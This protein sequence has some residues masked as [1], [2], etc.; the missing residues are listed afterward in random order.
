MASFDFTHLP[1]GGGNLGPVV[2]GL[3]AAVNTAL[4]VG[5]LDI[6]ACFTAVL[7]VFTLVFDLFFARIFSGRPKVGKDSATD[8][9]ALFFIPSQN[10]VVTLWGMGIRLL[11]AKGL[12]ISTSNPAGRQHYVK[13]AAAAQADLVRQFGAH[14]GATYYSQYAYL[15]SLKN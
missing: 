14:A 7:D 6:F 9:V 15:S 11:E 5:E 1:G 13:L 10:P 2:T 4:C 8:D 3:D 12:P